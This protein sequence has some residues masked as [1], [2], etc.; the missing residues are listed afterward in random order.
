MDTGT[1]IDPELVGRI[2]EPFFTTK[3]VGKGTGLGLAT[4]YGIV[5]NAGGTVVASSERGRGTA[6]DVCLP[7]ADGGAVE[8]PAPE[9]AAAAEGGT[10]EILLVDDEDAVRDIVATMLERQGYRV[11][12][13]EGP[14]RR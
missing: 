11:T 9:A 4:V 12:Q 2:F 8:R 6:F 14:S 1:G 13:A 7:L 10:E 5:R 3:D